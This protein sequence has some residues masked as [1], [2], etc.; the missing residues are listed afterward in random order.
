MN[1]KYVNQQNYPKKEDRVLR[2]P[3]NKKITVPGQSISVKEIMDR[4]EKGKPIPQ[5]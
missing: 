4:Y 2:S 5:E 1:K 3:D